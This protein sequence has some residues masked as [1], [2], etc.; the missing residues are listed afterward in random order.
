[1][2]T[3]K[4]LTSILSCYNNIFVCVCILCIIA[5]TYNCYQ[6]DRYNDTIVFHNDNP[7]T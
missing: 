5:A 1:M 2:S 3:L 6:H 4:P 7:K